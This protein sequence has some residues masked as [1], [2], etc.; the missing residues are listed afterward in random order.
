MNS[1]VLYEV[2]HETEALPTIFTTERLLSRVNYFVSFEGRLRSKVFLT[3]FTAEQL[4]SG[5][6]SLV[7]G[8]DGGHANEAFP[9]L[10]TAERPLS[11]VNSHVYF[12]IGCR[13]EAFSTMFTVA[14]LFI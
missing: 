8:F 12:E 6:N 14:S 13:S 9:T 4:L 2:R 11:S 5:V 10:V 3:L 1:P 7:V